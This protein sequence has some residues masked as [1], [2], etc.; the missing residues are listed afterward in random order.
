VKVTLIGTGY[1]GLVTG[2]C[3]ADVGNDVLCFDVDARKIA[4]LE[5]GEIPIYEPGLREI[6]RANAAAGRLTFT[7]DAKKATRHGRIQMI[8]VGTPPGE[9]GSADLS[10]VLAAARSI[11]EH[12]DAPKIV[13]DKSTVPVGTAGQGACRHHGRPEEAR[14]RH[15]V[16][17]GVEPEFLKEGAAVEDFMRPG[18]HRGRRGRCRGRHGASRALRPVPAQPRSACR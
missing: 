2:A 7:T 16:Q 9:D 10:H 6:V 13:V 17:R 3:L 14:R 11:A 12:M 15:R 5:G 18:P 8:A 4:M 1:V